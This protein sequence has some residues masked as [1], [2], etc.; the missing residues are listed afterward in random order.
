MYDHSLA[1]RPAC[2]TD[3]ECP[4]HLACIEEKCQDPCYTRGQFCG[5]NAK[6]KVENNRATCVARKIQKSTIFVAFNS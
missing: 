3:P 2:T 6:C 4:D 5:S 1:P